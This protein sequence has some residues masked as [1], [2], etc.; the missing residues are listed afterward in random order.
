ME[1]EG[2][3]QNQET[4]DLELEDI[5]LDAVSGYS[6]E[7]LN[8]LLNGE[9]EGAGEGEGDE[10]KANTPAEG[11]KPGAKPQADPGKEQSPFTR[12]E[13]EKLTKQVGDKEG[14][15]QKQAQE[16]GQLR[17]QFQEFSA[18][19][20]GGGAKAPEFDWSDPLG[21]FQRAQAAQTQNLTRV[22]EEVLAAIPEVE[23]LRDD[24]A[25]LAAE[26]GFPREAVES[27][28]QHLV[29]Q[30]PLLKSYATRVKLA[31]ENESLKAEN[32]K[33]RVKPE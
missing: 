25:K 6:E 9:E 4:T 3:E 27:F 22:R 28:R 15:I 2:Q 14:F 19:L 7:E 31:K 16:I 11:V 24:I 17:R 13:F 8:A 10:K 30:V 26:D 29:G 1:D 5:D 12:E 20:Q 32:E 33:L 21:S 18:L 23:S